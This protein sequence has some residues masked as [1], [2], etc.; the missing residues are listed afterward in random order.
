MHKVGLKEFSLVSSGADNIRNITIGELFVMISNDQ[1]R[2]AETSEAN[3]KTNLFAL[4]SLIK[5]IGPEFRLEE[6]AKNPKYIRQYRTKLLEQRKQAGVEEEKAKRGINNYLRNLSAIFNYAVKVGHI[7]DTFVPSLE[8]FKTV[9]RKQFELYTE[10]EEQAIL[11]ELKKCRHDGWLAFAIIIHTGVR[12]G[13]V[14]R[15]TQRDT[16]PMRWKDVDFMRGKI[17]WRSKGTET[18][19][20]M[21]EKLREIL[22]NRKKE[23]GDN[24]KPDKFVVHVTRPTLSHEI[25]RVKKALGIEKEGAAHAARHAFALKILEHGGSSA[26]IMN[27]MGHK[28]LSTTS[29]YIQ[30]YDERNEMIFKRMGKSG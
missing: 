29:A 19:V 30:I 14:C 21:H 18:R 22:L 8:R 17:T 15:Q 6:L 4:Q 11:S 16:R 2:K 24:W 5:I 28:D 10:A 12:A 1:H 26:D 20:P 25:T 23:I 13:A 27:I 7:P 3:F 9:R